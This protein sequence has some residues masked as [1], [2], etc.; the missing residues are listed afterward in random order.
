M[1]KLAATGN[2][3]LRKL[4]GQ[5]RI[6]RVG[7]TRITVTLPRARRCRCIGSNRL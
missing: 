3:T 4:D 1:D 5:V 6:D 7:T 2:K